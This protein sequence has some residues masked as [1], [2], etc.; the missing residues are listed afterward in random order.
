MSRDLRA[1]L[2]C[3]AFLG[4]FPLDSENKHTHSQKK[5]P[6]EK[7]ESRKFAMFQ[8]EEAFTQI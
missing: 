2:K 6:E 3:E 8:T 4:H 7:K 1:Q 5:K